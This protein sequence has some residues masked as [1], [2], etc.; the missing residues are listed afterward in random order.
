VTVQAYDRDGNPFEAEAEGLFA[1][2]LQHEND[3]LDGV[4]LIDHVS[5]FKRRHIERDLRKRASEQ[6]AAD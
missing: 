4:L 5:Y 1:V 6:A 2:A 3:H